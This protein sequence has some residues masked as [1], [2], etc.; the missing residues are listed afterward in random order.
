ME[1]FALHTHTLL[2]EHCRKRMLTDSKRQKI[3]KTTS[4][5]MSSGHERAVPHRNSQQPMAAWRTCSQHS[6]RGWGEAQEAP[7]LP[8]E[9]VDFWG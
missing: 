6:S 2:G 5:T 9:L 8:E 7:S 1:C 4:E 3:R